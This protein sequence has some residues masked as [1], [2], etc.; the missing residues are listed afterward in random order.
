MKE[1]VIEILEDIISDDI[2]LKTCTSL[3]DDKYL[4]SYDIVSLVSDLNEAFGVDI[5]VIHLLPENFNS[6]DAIVAL[7]ESLQ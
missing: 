4:D 1:A 5:N 2:D 3:I 6:I 7:I